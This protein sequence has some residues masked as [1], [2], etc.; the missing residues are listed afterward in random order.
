MFILGTANFGNA[1]QGSMRIVDVESAY[2]LVKEFIKLGGQ[3][4]DTAEA[5]GEAK[6]ILQ[7]LHNLNFTVGT[8]IN[9]KKLLDGEDIIQSIQSIEEQFEN[10][11]NYILLHDSEFLKEATSENI[12]LFQNYLRDYNIKLGI[13]IYH[14]CELEEALNRFEK[15]SL[16]QAPLNYLDRRFLSYSFIELCSFNNIEVNYRSIFLQGKL[17]HDYNLLHPFF[18]NF[19]EVK[20]YYADFSTSPF[21]NLLIFNIEFIKSI[22][23]FSKVTLGVETISQL[24]EIHSIVKCNGCAAEKHSYRK[25]DFNE[26]LCIPMNWKLR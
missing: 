3:Q 14:Q 10:K 17:L 6:N 13:S 26:S 2:N 19:D 24:R 5:Y 18:Q 8:K 16:V 15:I 22:T 7:A 20:S 9:S 12:K 4:L 11:L 25:V 21:K 1:Y 23:D